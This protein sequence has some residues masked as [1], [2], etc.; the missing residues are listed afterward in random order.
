M[1]FV[2]FPSVI[3]IWL[4]QY[5]HSRPWCQSRVTQASAG[6]TRTQEK[7]W[8]VCECSQRKKWRR[9]GQ[10][11]PI[12]FAFHQTTQPKSGGGVVWWN[13]IKIDQRTGYGPISPIDLF[14]RYSH[15][16]TGSKS[17]RLI[18]KYFSNSRLNRDLWRSFWKSFSAYIYDFI[19]DHHRS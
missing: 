19:N 7:E 2:V 15:V 5:W 8:C 13:A 11:S 1:A 6:S 12:F 14:H 17:L 3:P 10:I 18:R 16:K 4:F 9:T